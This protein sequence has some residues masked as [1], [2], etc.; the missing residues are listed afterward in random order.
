MP[1]LDYLAGVAGEVQKVVLVTPTAITADGNS[2]GVDSTS[3][4]GKCLVDAAIFNTKGTTPT[5]DI[6]LQESSEVVPVDALTYAGTGTG[7]ISEIEVGPDAVHETITV[8]LSSASAFAVSGGTTGAMAAGVVGTRYVSQ[9]CSFIIHAGA[10][11]FVN[12]DAF[13]FHI[14]KDRAYTDVVDGAITQV[15]ANIL[16]YKTLNADE[17]GKFL[18]LNYTLAQTAIDLAGASKANPCI[19]TYVGHGLNS[20]DT[21]TIAGITQNDWAA[22]LNKSHIITK[23]T[24]DTFSIPVDTSG[25]AVAYNAAT[26]PG[27]IVSDTKSYTVA[28][29]I[30]G[31]KR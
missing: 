20:L 14:T 27:T 26:D 28:A 6:K 1:S 11:A 10:V 29:N 9:Q 31:F 19:I 5:M 21:V 4:S 17:L 24:A 7:V 23:L 22:A 18:R 15:G 16:T 30:F 8:T 3:F 2:P 13:G 25:I 12:T